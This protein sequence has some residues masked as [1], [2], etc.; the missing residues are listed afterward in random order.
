MNPT[1]D[2][3][4][5]LVDG[6]VVMNGGGHHDRHI[7]VPT[8]GTCLDVEGHKAVGWSVPS[9]IILDMHLVPVLGLSI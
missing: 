1:H 2:D 8:L 4:A 6:A 5:V 3:D 7:H 9:N